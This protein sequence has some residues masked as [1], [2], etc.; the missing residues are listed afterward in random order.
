MNRIICFSVADANNTNVFKFYGGTT[1]CVT[2]SGAGDITANGIIKTNDIEAISP[3][4]AV[5][6]KNNLNVYGD[7]RVDT[8]G[9]YDS[10]PST[11]SFISPCI[12]GTELSNQ[13]LSVKCSI[14][15]EYYRFYSNRS[16]DDKK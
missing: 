9:N 12:I 14:N 4:N 10:T 3:N 1:N 8:I 15:D 2:I 7:I 5:N 13:P 6:I 16:N 11:I